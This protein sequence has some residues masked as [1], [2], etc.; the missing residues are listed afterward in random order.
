MTPLSEAAVTLLADRWHELDR[1][2]GEL[3]EKTACKFGDPDLHALVCGMNAITDRIYEIGCHS[4]HDVRAVAGI[5]ATSSTLMS[6]D[7][8]SVCSFEKL[9]P[10]LILALTG[11]PP[12]IP[13]AA[14]PV[15][16]R[17]DARILEICAVL[18]DQQ[19]DIDRL[20][21]VVDDLPPEV[22]DGP[23]FLAFDAY[24]DDVWPGFEASMRGRDG[25]LGELIGL[26]PVTAGGVQAK[27]AAV[28]A[29]VEASRFGGDQRYDHAALVASVLR[30]LVGRAYRPVGRAR[31]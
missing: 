10:M 8:K 1:E 9:V 24:L 20:H 30:P 22:E 23:E 21:K 25:L 17:P 11:S 7:E 19:Q 26:E 2:W 16:A 5:L 18:A 27:A 28:L 6:T 4:P 12:P 15:S 13:D 3:D 31:P 14:L 29:V